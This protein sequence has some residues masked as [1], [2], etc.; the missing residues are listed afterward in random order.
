MRIKY[1]LI[2]FIMCSVFF[3]S[4]YRLHS[5]Y[6]INDFVVVNPDRIGFDEIDYQLI[7]VNI[8]DGYGITTH[9][10]EDETRYKMNVKKS[11]LVQQSIHLEFFKDR[12]R[13]GNNV[14][15]WRP[16]GYPLFVYLIYKFVGVSPL[17]VKFIQVVLIALA[18]SFMP[19]IG[20][21]YWGKTGIISGVVA[22]VA[23]IHFYTPNPTFIL[24]ENL[25]VFLFAV[26][27][28][29]F[30]IWDKMRRIFITALL[31]IILGL[32]L[33]VKG[34]CIFIAFLFPAYLFFRLKRRESIFKHVFVFVLCVAVMIAPW[35]IFSSIKTHQLVLLCTQQ[36]HDLLAG[37]NEESIKTGEYTPSWMIKNPDNLYKRLKEKNFSRIKMLATFLRQYYKNIPQLLVHKLKAGFQRIVFILLAM[38]SYYA[39]TFYFK[40]THCYRDIQIPIFPLM[41]F[42]N[43][44]LIT[45]I[46]Y[47]ME[48][49][50][51]PFV[52]S[53]LIP[54]TYLPFYLLRILINRR[55][56]MGGK[57]L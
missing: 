26:W 30:S 14:A 54:A 43:I 35:S 10:N 23:F 20:F 28:L 50:V 13:K 7:A 27:I 36:G 45:L 22:S 46:L 51:E 1:L 6:K 38:F 32:A 12:L 3:Y 4:F 42:I 19:L 53:F 24:S 31:G 9:F 34:S 37:N 11:V 25:Y 16:P 21:L 40:Q 18:A 47:G 17:Y 2:V 44:L 49:L 29:L 8:L 48:R 56:S 5:V 57:T 33:L 55:G 52:Y 41:F 15:T 39:V